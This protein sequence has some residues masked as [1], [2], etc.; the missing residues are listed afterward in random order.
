MW[1]YGDSSPP[2]RVTGISKA[3]KMFHTYKEHGEFNVTVT[4]NNSVGLDT[5]KIVV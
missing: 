4:A 3:K 1:D 2:V 5:T